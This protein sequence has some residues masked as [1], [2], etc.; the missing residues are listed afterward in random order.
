[1][2]AELSIMPKSAIILRYTPTLVPILS[3]LITTLSA[4]MMT[5][6]N[7]QNASL[8]EP[9]NS[10]QLASV[11]PNEIKPGQHDDGLNP[12]SVRCGTVPMLEKVYHRSFNESETKDGGQAG[13]T[14]I[15]HGLDAIS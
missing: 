5:S 13:E 11:A 1:M 8:Q 10:N 6:A 3:L 15:L 7:K 14:R 4:Q 2:L 12:S 9:I